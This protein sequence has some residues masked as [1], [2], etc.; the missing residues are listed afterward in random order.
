MLLT[1]KDAEAAL[2]TSL[3]GDS[4]DTHG[5]EDAPDPAAPELVAGRVSEAQ[6]R[7]WVAGAK[8]NARLIYGIGGVVAHA[9][10][11]GVAALV[12]S[13]AEKGFVTPHRIRLEEGAVG[14]LIQRTHRP[15]LKGAVL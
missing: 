2:R 13:L 9:C 7:A 3:R 8:P 12:R 14:Q 6:L 10:S 5:G 1:K 4:D 11:P 15:V